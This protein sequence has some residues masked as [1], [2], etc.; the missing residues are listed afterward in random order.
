MKFKS[1]SLTVAMLLGISALLRPTAS[2]AV[3]TCQ[4]CA[5]WYAQCQQNSKSPYC[6]SWAELCGVCGT[7]SAKPDKSSTVLN[8]TVRHD[9]ADDQARQK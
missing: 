2:L 3:P 6:A 7:P 8:H 1:A 5:Y 9:I 4:T